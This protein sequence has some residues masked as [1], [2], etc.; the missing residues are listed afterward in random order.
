MIEK[1]VERRGDKWCVIHCKGPD[2]GKPIKCFATKEEAEKMHQAIMANEGRGRAG[3]PQN[4][5]NEKK[6]VAI[7]PAKC[8]A[9]DLFPEPRKK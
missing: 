3:G 7:D 1:K 4:Q 2:A 5:S 6:S 9:Y 8:S